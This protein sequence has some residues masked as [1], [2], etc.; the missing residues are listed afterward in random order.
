M[1]TNVSLVI[2]AIIFIL[3]I[4]IL[5]VYN[6]FTRQDDMSY[7][8][9]LK[10]TATFADKVRTTGVLD[11]DIYNDYLLEIGATQNTFNVEM[12]VHKKKI[13]DLGNGKY[14]DEYIIY[15]TDD[16]LEVLEKG[17]RYNLE[18]GE[19]FFVRVN[20]TNITKADSLLAS[21][22]VMDTKSKINIDYGGVVLV[23]SIKK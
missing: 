7:N 2:T 22:K 3:L 4:V 8:L 12:E 21:I 14:K 1:E 11:N 16:I 5:P 23:N 20:N 10:S 18:K 19:K 15:Y 17:G 9:I 13:I 6:V